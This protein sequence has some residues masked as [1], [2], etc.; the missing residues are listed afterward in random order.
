[1]R[2]LI[3]AF[4]A[5]V[6]LLGFAATAQASPVAKSPAPAA[7]YTPAPIVWGPCDSPTL[8]SFGAQCGMLTV[9]MDYAKPNGTK[10]QLAVS[11]VLHTTT[12][13]KGVML[14]N[15]GGPG[16]SGLIYSVFQTFVPNGGGA[17]YDWIGFDPR[18][19]GSS[20]P[21]LTCNPN[22]F[23]G[24]RPPYEPTTS[25]IYKQWINRSK[26]YAADCKD[27]ASS[28]LFKH[29]KTTDSVADME[30]LRIALGQQKTN[31]YGFSY[32][33]YLGSVYAT[34]HPTRVGKFIFDGTVDPQ[35]VFYKSN[36]DQDRA[37]Q[38]TF[39]IYF[40]WLAKYNSIYHVGATQAAVRAN[41]FKALRQLDQKAA[42]GILGGDE[43]ID[44]FTSA[45]YYVYDWEDIAQ[46][47]SDY[48]NQGDATA[49]IARYVDANPT[50]TGADNGYAMYL[51]TQCTDAPWPQSQQKLDQDSYKLVSQGYNYFTWSNAW[52]N[53][54]CA[55]W[56][57]QA[58]QPVDVT[59][60][61]VKTPILM[62]GETYDAATPFAGSLVVRKLFPTASLIEGLDGSTHAGSLSGV[63]CTDDTIATY[64]LTGAV[65]PR[66]SGNQSDKICPPVPQPT[67]TPATAA[68]ASSASRAGTGRA[69]VLDQLRATVA[70]SATHG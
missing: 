41:Y 56:K 5:A 68:A 17:P 62:I 59:G 54:P 63:A 20:V 9:P 32:G 10:I 67:P 70:F 66:K 47:F 2:K 49:L 25:K 8:Q 55:Y 61:K 40:T 46:A 34:L 6:V 12:D 57:F 53:G 18:G 44:V 7:E 1:M 60:A 4:I 69:Q 31:Y 23:H 64:L 38:K 48:I 26:A 21:A 22:F 16:G 19:V 52:F 27:A 58:N 14:V 11:R 15:P 51:A 36:L 33:T 45:G 43:L 50:T 30:S 24:D 28:A 42:G 39:D 37:F 65:P 29:V 13:Y 3:A 35:R